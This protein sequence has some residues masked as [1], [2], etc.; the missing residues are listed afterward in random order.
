MWRFDQLLGEKEWP[1]CSL[2]Q[3]RL[4]VCALLALRNETKA[5]CWLAKGAATT[6]GGTAG[7]LQCIRMYKTA[8]SFMS[9]KSRVVL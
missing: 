7:C 9:L 8:K 2:L 3:M 4:W 5:L 6:G 1:W